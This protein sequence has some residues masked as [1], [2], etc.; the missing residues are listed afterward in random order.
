[1]IN[2]EFY[3][4]VL[5]LILFL[6][7]CYDFVY[8]FKIFLGLLKKEMEHCN[9]FSGNLNMNLIWMTDLHLSYSQ[10]SVKLQSRIGS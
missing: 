10:A 4:F 2:I 7:F 3:N 1:M 6:K 8:K 9:M 5:F